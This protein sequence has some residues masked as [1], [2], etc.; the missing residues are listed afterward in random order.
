MSPEFSGSKVSL[1][2]NQH[3]AGSKL[4]TRLAKAWDRIEAEMTL[5][6]KSSVHIGS[7]GVPELANMRQDKIDITSA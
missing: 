1:K 4:T 2:R 7:I 3:K 6:T 5:E